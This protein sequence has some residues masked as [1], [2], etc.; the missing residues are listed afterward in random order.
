M[1]IDKPK[2]FILSLDTPEGWFK[3][4]VQFILAFNPVTEDHWLKRIFWDNTNDDDVVEAN[5]NL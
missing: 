2:A 4:Y 1:N 5:T 3:N